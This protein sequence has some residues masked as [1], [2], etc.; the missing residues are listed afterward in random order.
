MIDVEK[1]VGM[2]KTAGVDFFTGVP[3][4]PLESFCA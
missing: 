3:D 2:M 1:F 4:S